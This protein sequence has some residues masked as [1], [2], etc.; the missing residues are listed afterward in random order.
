MTG[1]YTYSAQAGGIVVTSP[2]S[3]DYVM[4]GSTITVNVETVDRF[5]I[6][7]VVVGTSAGS[8]GKIQ[9]GP[10][11]RVK[12]AIPQAASGTITL[13][14]TA[15]GGASNQH[16][17][18]A[19]EVSLNIDLEGIGLTGITIPGP[20]SIGANTTNQRL[21][22][23]GTYSDGVDR[24]IAGAAGIAYAVTMPSILTIGSDGVITPVS[25]GLTDVSATY[26]GFAAAA[27]VWVSLPLQLGLRRSDNS[28]SWPGQVD[29]T[30]YDLVVGDL[31]LLRSTGG[32]F[33]TATTDCA[34]DS[35][36]ATSVTSAANPAVGNGFYF[37]A[38][39]VK[40]GNA[41]SYDDFADWPASKQAASRDAGITGS[42]RGC[43]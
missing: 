33:A 17:R 25:S 23:N 9:S 32:N 34:V 41:L 35:T 27:R 28:V 31:N 5:P 43:P 3:G 1:A 11:W 24:S 7:R 30:A 18:I 29:A 8:Y 16:M 4:P 10:P 20:L 13:L 39:P 40:Y 14:T 38:R 19:P 37:L 36:T 26:Q 22:V 42:G 21:P 12:L 6:T 2:R 15:L